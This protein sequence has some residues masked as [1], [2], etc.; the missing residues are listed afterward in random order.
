MP[1]RNRSEAGQLLAGR[2]QDYANRPDV[3]IF[4][5]PRGGVP[6]AAEIA[7]ALN[8]P[9]AVLVVRKLGVPGQ[10]ELA[11]G[12]VI[13]GGTVYINR[14]I[15]GELGI[16][17]SVIEAVTRQET[18]EVARRESLYNRGRP[19][20][21]VK[22]KTVILVDDGVA[23]GASLLLAAQALHNQEAA[24]VILA[25]PVAPPP[26]VREF[27]R[28]ADQIVC[29]AQPYPFVSVGQWYEDFHQLTDE[30]VFL[31]LDRLPEKQP[32]LK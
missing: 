22:G 16:P 28:V 12:A 5:L 19:M 18:R 10:S 29:L 17:E 6:V 8:L 2:L 30:E 32:E 27:N 20:P 9:L 23:T 21:D 3:L 4:A 14:S 24:Q 31:I 7:T 15:V 13:N 1:F 11:M 26:T 25:I